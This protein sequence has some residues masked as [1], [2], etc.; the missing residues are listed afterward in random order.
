MSARQAILWFVNRP[1]PARCLLALDPG[2]SKCQALLIAPD[3]T[4]LSTGRAECPGLSGRSRELVQAAARQALGNHQPRSCH[5][6]TVS[7][8]LAAE[9]YGFPP[10]VRVTVHRLSELDGPLAL[11]D[12]AAGLV[13]VA[14]T[15]ARIS[16]RQVDGR[17]LTIDGLGPLLG[18]HGSGYA[19]GRTAL[20]AVAMTVAA[21]GTR[22]ATRL[23]DP[24]INACATALQSIGDDP[25]RC[26]L[27]GVALASYP[28]SVA[29]K[30][31]PLL[32]LS[33]IPHDRSVI[34]GLA[35][36]VDDAARAGDET[37]RQILHAAADAL[38]ASVRDLVMWMGTAGDDLPLVGTGS[39]IR[40]SDIYWD[41]FC[42]RLATV[43]PAIRPARIPHPPVVGTALAALQKIPGVDRAT[44]R[45]RLLETAGSCEKG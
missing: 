2:G 42:A 32:R 16:A 43:T 45:V 21:R 8:L 3:G 18:D 10:D 35:R 23:C 4:V 28:P 30:L 44:A 31:A 6:A 39:V 19:I 37:A 12:A 11:I 5:V 25:N 20:R 36:G 24:L 38:A 33:L 22:P 7:G 34:A 41:R 26:Q 27:A 15:G 17:C 29:E 40:H 13:V 9:D 1:G 14:G